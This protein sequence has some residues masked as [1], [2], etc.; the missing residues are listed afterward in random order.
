L[1]PLWAG[2]SWSTINTIGTVNTILAIYA[3][4]TLRPNGA[5]RADRTVN[6][7]HTILTINTGRAL[8]AG[9]PLWANWATGWPHDVASQDIG[10]VDVFVYVARVDIK[11]EVAVNPQRVRWRATA[12]MPNTSRLAW[13]ALDARC[14]DANARRPKQLDSDC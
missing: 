6:A 11:V 13:R 7:V 9:R 2:R 1:R 10:T 14:G 4:H 5:L 8:R 3:G 12:L